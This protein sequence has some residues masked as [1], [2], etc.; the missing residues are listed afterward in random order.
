MEL[1]FDS[2]FW[3]LD[4]TAPSRSTW[5]QF[6][7]TAGFGEAASGQYAAIFKDQ[8][9]EMD[10]LT[11]LSHEL[12]L[13]MGFTKAGARIRILRFKDAIINPQT[14]ASTCLKVSASLVLNFRFLGGISFSILILRTKTLFSSCERIQRYSCTGSQLQPWR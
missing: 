3:P 1:T 13:Q 11:E 8:E 5:N 9:M 12:L 10:M 6:F 14:G 4:A 7:L 2:L